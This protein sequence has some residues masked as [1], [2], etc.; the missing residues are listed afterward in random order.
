MGMHGFDLQK[1]YEVSR[2]HAASH[3]FQDPILT[4]ECLSLKHEVIPTGID[5]RFALTCRHI[6]PETVPENLRHNGDIDLDEANPY[7]G[8]MDLWEDME[9]K[10]LA[11]RE[12]VGR[13]RG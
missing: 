5:L 13:R 12:R 3:T 11:K 9:R 2:H 6:K 8:D 4:H 10:R 1:Y 7:D